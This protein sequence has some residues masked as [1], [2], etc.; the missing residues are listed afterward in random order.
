[1]VM[2]VLLLLLLMVV[3]PS[4]KPVTLVEQFLH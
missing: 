3:M 4:Y 1:M 2:V